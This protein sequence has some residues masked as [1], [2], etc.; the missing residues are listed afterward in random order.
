MSNTLEV[1]DICNCSSILSVD[2]SRP[3]PTIKAHRTFALYKHPMPSRHRMFE[4]RYIFTNFST[5]SPI[6]MKY[7]PVGNFNT[8]ILKFPPPSTSLTPPPAEDTSNPS[9]SNICTIESIGHLSNST[10][11]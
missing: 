11:D 1:L 6:W 2:R 8:S 7:T 5:L 9:T 4:S 10:A 3:V